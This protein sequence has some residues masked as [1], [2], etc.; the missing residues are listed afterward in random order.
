MRRRR[1]GNSDDGVV[2]VIV[3]F[4]FGASVLVVLLALVIDIGAMQWERRQ[5]QNGADAAVARAA[6]DCV[7]N[8]GSTHIC[9]NLAAPIG[10]ASLNAADRTETITATDL[11]GAG[12]PALTACTTA[13]TGVHNCPTAT[14]PPNYVRVT[15]STWSAGG[16]RFLP[17]FFS[18]AIP[19]FGPRTL[20]ACSLAAWGAPAEVLSSVPFAIGAGCWQQQLSYAAAQGLPS[21][22]TN[23][24]YSGVAGVG[25]SPEPSNYEMALALS[26]NAAGS[27]SNNCTSTANINGGFGWLTP[28]TNGTD[29]CFLD[30]MYNQTT[31][32]PGASLSQ[33]SCQDKMNALVNA[34]PT[35]N[36]KYTPAYFNRISYIPIFDSATGTTYHVTGFAAFY[37]TGFQVPALGKNANPRNTSVACPANSVCIYGWFLKSSLPASSAASLTSSTGVTNTSGTN[38]GLNVVSLVG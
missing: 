14:M 28:T 18:S 9:G 3:T 29:T 34:T 15:T 6:L 8:D 23:P 33:A 31:S 7:L 22:P 2:A 17:Q 19:G 26:G 38:Y 30:F 12:N 20:S 35:S 16:S 25:T 32:N 11:C 1:G 10:V 37:M 13:G 27:G 36:N 4:F 24:A 5:L 21:Y